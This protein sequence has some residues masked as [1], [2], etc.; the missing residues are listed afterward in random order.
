MFPFSCPPTLSSLLL[1]H[2]AN[3]CPAPCKFH[4]A[5]HR[6][7]DTCSMYIELIQIKYQNIGNYLPATSP[8]IHTSLSCYWL[9]WILFPGNKTFQGWKPTFFKEN[10]KEKQLYTTTKTGKKGI[11]TC[12]ELKISYMPYVIEW[13]VTGCLLVLFVIAFLYFDNFGSA[14]QLLKLVAEAGKQPAQERLYYLTGNRK[15]RR[16]TARQGSV[17]VLFARAGVGMDGWP[18]IQKESH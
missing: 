14:L 13:K 3:S 1:F 5:H 12:V 2:V 17:T 9:I 16:K 6:H 8:S 10:K 15:S 7:S 18:L 11:L 4:S